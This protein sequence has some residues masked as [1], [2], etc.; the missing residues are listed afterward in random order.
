MQPCL[1]CQYCAHRVPPSR[2][3]VLFLFSRKGVLGGRVLTM[4]T[5]VHRAQGLHF[6]LSQVGANSRTQRIPQN[7]LFHSCQARM[8]LGM[9][10]DVS[11]T[12]LGLVG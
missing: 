10:S 1:F 11:V 3:E 12:E 4:D 5:K 9:F 7:T 2:N 8:A 6:N